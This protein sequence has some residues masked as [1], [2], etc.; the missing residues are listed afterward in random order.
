M[1]HLEFYDL[2]DLIIHDWPLVKWQVVAFVTAYGAVYAAA[3]LDLAF[4]LFRRK[5]LNA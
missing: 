2:R 5:P 4:F 3:C 1:P